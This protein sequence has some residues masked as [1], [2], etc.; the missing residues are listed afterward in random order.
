LQDLFQ[1]CDLARF[2]PVKSSQELEAFIP[3]LE[4]TLREIQ[5]LNS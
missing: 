1:A 4:T 5:N 3:R 2:A